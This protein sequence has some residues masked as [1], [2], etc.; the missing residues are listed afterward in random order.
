MARKVRLLPIA[1]HSQWSMRNLP[2]ANFD[3]AL[4]YIIY[5]SWFFVV[6]YGYIPASLFVVF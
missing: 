2:V 3:A 1:T 6:I 4:F 5:R